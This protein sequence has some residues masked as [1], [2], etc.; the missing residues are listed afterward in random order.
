LTILMLGL[1]Q[2]YSIGLLKN[3]LCPYAA[4]TLERN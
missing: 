1:F 2:D 4:L 3:F